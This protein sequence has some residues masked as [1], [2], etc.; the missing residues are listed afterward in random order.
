MSKLRCNTCTQWQ[1][2]FI[3]WIKKCYYKSSEQPIIYHV[4]NQFGATPSHYPSWVPTHE[5]AESW[6]PKFDTVS[7]IPSSYIDELWSEQNGQP[8]ADNI[9]ECLSKTHWP[10][11]K[12]ATII[13]IVCSGTC[14]GKGSWDYIGVALVT[15]SYCGSVLSH[16]V[17]QSSLASTRLLHS[18]SL[19][20]AK[21]K[22]QSLCLC[23]ETVK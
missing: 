19:V 17:G 3:K 8:F 14:S 16:L 21:G 4:S 12:M 15:F 2:S 10:Q 6:L 18:L 1:N 7:K 13:V 23:R 22:C 9:S 20:T 5:Q 11:H